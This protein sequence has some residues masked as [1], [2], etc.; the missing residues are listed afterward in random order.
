MTYRDSTDDDVEGTVF[1]E[2][3]PSAEFLLQ[4]QGEEIGDRLD[5]L[6]IVA[7]LWQVVGRKGVECL[8]QEPDWAETLNSWAETT[9]QN[10]SRLLELLDALQAYPVPEPLGSHESMV[11]YDLRR[12]LKEQLL[13]MTIDTAL[14]TAQAM[15]VLLGVQPDSSSQPAEEDEA[16]GVPPWEGLSTRLEG[17]LWR[18]DRPAVEQLLAELVGRFRPEPLLFTALSDGGQP[19]QVFRARLAQR[20]LRALVINLPRLGLLR[21]TYQ[22]LRMAHAM[23]QVNQP[24]GRK[25]SEFGLLFQAGFMPV[26]EALVESSAGWEAPGPT[27]EELMELLEDVAGPFVDLWGDYSQTLQL[28]TL[29]SIADAEWTTLA[30]FIH[31][32]GGDIFDA[33]FMTLA[34]LRGILH[35]GVGAYLDYLRDNPDPLHPVRL[36]EDLDHAIPRAQV[37]RLIG[38]VLRALIEN[39]EVYK[40]YNT[41]TAQSDYGENLYMLLDFLRLKA[42]YERRDWYLRPFYM[43]HHVLA[44]S[45][46]GEALGP[47]QQGFSQMAGEM[48]DQYLKQL[49][50][51]EQAHGIRLRTVSD[52]LQER[53]VKPLAVNRMCALIEPA[54]AEAGRPDGGGHFKRLWEETIEH[55]TTPTGAGLDVP[56]WLRQFE[57]EVKRVQQARSTIAA[58]SGNLLVTPQRLSWPQLEAQLDNWDKPLES[59]ATTEGD[60]GESAQG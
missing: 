26:V 32:Y 36:I 17:A 50:R 49:T 25:T 31:R 55:T 18:G 44:R 7:R 54:M 57:E 39:Y 41:T 4:S 29:E 47:W 10:R 43:A 20:T 56:P 8:A 5:F 27:D 34:N 30:E 21:E 37:E 14:E 2:G 33:K 19:R 48:A 59:P 45:T 38:Y 40:D 11:E 51:L 52:R 42:Q 46:R 23:E 60:T 24:L 28:S 53:F 9:R 35:A 6:S 1:D 15:V 22:L 13:D 16:S 58:A 12:D 3:P